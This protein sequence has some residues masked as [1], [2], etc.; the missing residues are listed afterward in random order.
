M[1]IVH[2]HDFF[3]RGNSRA[4]H[5]M[6]R[7][8]VRRGHEAHVVAGV[9]P[10][11]PADG[12]TEDGVRFHTYPYA[13]GAPAPAF[14]LHARFHGRRAF[15]DALAAGAPDIVL[16]NQPVCAW[17]VDALA[18]RRPRAYWFISP[19]PEEFRI[20]HG[21]G[22]ASAPQIGL[23][24]WMEDRAV[25]SARGVLVASKYMARELRRWHPRVSAERIHHAPHAVDVE[26]FHPRGRDAARR[27]FGLRSEFVVFTMRRLVARMG[28]DLLIHAARR[29]QGARVWI[30]GEGPQRGRLEK[31]ARDA[32]VADR[33][34]FLGQIPEDELPDRYRAA[35]VFVVPTRALEGFGMVLIEALA[36]GTPVVGTRVGAIP[37]VA[38]GIRGFVLAEPDPASIADAVARAQR[39]V[40][41]EEV[42]RRYAPDRIAE[43]YER[44][45]EAIASLR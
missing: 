35:D 3:A 26:R 7:A 44:I 18:R 2:V 21:D 1:R 32:G 15:R 45:L 20:E 14:L 19:W 24:W 23:R 5:D 36:C 31:I 42:L 22:I 30:G 40:D 8:L 43:R 38:G 37:E 6:L 33:V 13:F 11:G 41:V 34:T 9:G 12:T 28:L 10:D 17:A 39:P 29:L 27:R 16:L 25:R 4:G